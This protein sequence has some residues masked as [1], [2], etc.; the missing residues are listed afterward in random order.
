MPSEVRMSGSSDS[1]GE[2]E[3]DD[4]EEEYACRD[5]NLSRNSDPNVMGIVCPDNAL[6]PG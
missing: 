3:I 1:L 4:E 5:K 2:D 6:Q